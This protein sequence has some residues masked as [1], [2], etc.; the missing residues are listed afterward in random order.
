[1]RPQKRDHSI[2]IFDALG[3]RVDPGEVR[4]AMICAFTKELGIE[5]KE[6]SLTDDEGMLARRLYLEKY[7]RDEWNMEREIPKQ[8]TSPS[9]GDQACPLSNRQ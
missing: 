8:P 6:D 1:I 5:F 3:R 7:T 2:S 4:D 9:S